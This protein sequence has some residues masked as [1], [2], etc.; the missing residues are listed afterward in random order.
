MR[1][2]YGKIRFFPTPDQHLKAVGKFACAVVMHGVSTTSED[3]INGDPDSK[4]TYQVMLMQH[5]TSSF[6]FYKRNKPV[7]KGLVVD[8]KKKAGGIKKMFFYQTT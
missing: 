3:T 5:F 4:I 1:C 6:T 8:G 7:L 2:H